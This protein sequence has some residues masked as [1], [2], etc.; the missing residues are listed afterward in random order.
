MAKENHYRQGVF[1]PKNPEKY[2]GNVNQIIYRSGL[3]RRYMYFFDNNP[4]IKSWCSEEVVVKYLFDGDGRYHRYYPDFII[5]M[6]T[7]SGKTK[8]VMIEIKPFSETQPPKMGKR[9]TPKAL[10]NYRYQVEMFVKNQNKWEAARSYCQRNN[11]EFM[12]LTE[13]D[14][15]NSRSG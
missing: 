2:V 14:L 6:E 1:T 5:E 8:R 11:M 7:T 3:E 10:S 13:Q 9:K 4:F 12:I 15:G